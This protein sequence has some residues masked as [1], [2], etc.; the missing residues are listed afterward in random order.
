MPLYLKDPDAVLDYGVD[1]SAWL[2]EGEAITAS[3]WTVPSGITKDSQSHSGSDATV[4][5]SGG[6]TGLS[7][8][9]TNRITTN[10]GRT[11]DR[12]IQIVVRDR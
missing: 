11:D 9:V 3:N 1:W 2:S 4:W 7:Y 12:S 8:E 5:L 6:T 10:Q